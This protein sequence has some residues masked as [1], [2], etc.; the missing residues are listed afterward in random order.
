MSTG[1][2][3]LIGTQSV[4]WGE[5]AAAASDTDSTQVDKSQ[6]TLFNPVP[7]DAL[8]GMDTDRPNITNT[9]HTIDAG[10]VQVETGFYDDTHFHNRSNGNN[11][12][13]DTLTFGHINAR[14]GLTDNFE[15][16]ATIDGYTRSKT[17]DYVA[18]QT[19]RANGFGDTTIGGK[20][21]FWGDEGSDD[22]WATG[23]ALQP[24]IKLPTT[25]QSGVG[26]NHVEWS[27]GAPF[28][29]NLVDGFHLGLETAASQERNSSNNGY[30]AG[31]QNSASVDRV[32]FGNFDI[33]LEYAMH[34]T[35]ESHV[36]PN[37]SIDVGFTYPLTDNIVIDTGAIIGINRATPAIEWTS[38]ASFRF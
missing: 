30:V 32:I 13:T 31:W 34:V 10:H 21:N 8:R 11:S 38:G 16:N 3:A 28:V 4:A 22:A 27:L 12:V 14:L 29:I 20:L 25:A 9:P 1:L 6:Y 18:K 17:T 2:C 24:Q 5:E 23:F 15:I 37:Q 33:Y 35:T 19:T 7:A 36:Q 26:N